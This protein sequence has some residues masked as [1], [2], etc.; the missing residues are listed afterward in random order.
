[1][2]LLEPEEYNRLLKQIPRNVFELNELTPFEREF[3]E[4]SQSYAWLW[5]FLYGYLDRFSEMYDKVHEAPKFKFEL[6]RREGETYSRWANRLKAANWE[7]VNLVHSLL[8][9]TRKYMTWERKKSETFI[10]MLMDKVE[11]RWVKLR[12]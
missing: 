1:M 8:P 9:A 3:E 10:I 12:K 7:L 4:D 11:T 6:M 2:S 5:H